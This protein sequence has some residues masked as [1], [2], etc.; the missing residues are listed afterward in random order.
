MK[1]A[2]WI[3]AALMVLS[4][5]TACG[6]AGTEDSSAGT[7]APVWTETDQWPDN[8]FTRLVPAPEDGTVFATVQG[9]SK[10]YDYFAVSLREISQEGAEDYIQALRD[11][12][13]AAISQESETLEGGS[14]V[15]ADVF[16]NGDAAVSLSYSGDT[17]GLY[18]A[19]PQ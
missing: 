5:L 11:E 17:M 14:V 2:K 9:T 8:E 10:G 3:L 6:P 15:I 13:F 16:E 18:I 12:G 1:Q 7:S 19:Q 4:L